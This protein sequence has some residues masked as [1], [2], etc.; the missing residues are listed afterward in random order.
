VDTNCDP[1]PIDFPIAGNDDAIKSIRLITSAIATS[2][3]EAT[4]GRRKGDASAE[5]KGG[6]VAGGVIE[7]AWSA[8]PEAEEEA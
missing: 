5:G 6:S 7:E 1:D 4:G 3:S 8:A 2:I